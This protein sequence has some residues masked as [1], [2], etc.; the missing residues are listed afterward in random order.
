MRKIL[1][2]VMI[3]FMAVSLTA[4]GNSGT[5][6][7]NAD[8][9]VKNETETEGEEGDFYERF[10]GSEY[11]EQPD[12]EGKTVGELAEEG[13]S[14]IGHAKSRTQEQYFFEFQNR[15]EFENGITRYYSMI[16]DDSV[17]EIVKSTEFEESMSRL[18][19]SN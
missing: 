4:C 19:K 2:S 13:Y 10:E 6:E 14:Y 15:I 9:K 8:T 7:K 12:I 16:L 18:T 17:K 3:A 11:T 5:E 1:F